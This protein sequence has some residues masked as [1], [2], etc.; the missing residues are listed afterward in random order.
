MS[1]ACTLP[2]L[3]KLFSLSLLLLLISLLF[4]LLLLLIILLML[5]SLVVLSLFFQVMDATAHAKH[6]LLTCLPPKHTETTGI[7]IYIYIYTFITIYIY[8]YIQLL[9]NYMDL[10]AASSCFS[11]SS[12][13]SDSACSRSA[14]L[15]SGRHYLSNSGGIISLTLL[16]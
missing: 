2:F 9:E 7:L 5:L 15:A 6:K 4:L 13:A 10:E 1:H 11:C 14:M 16:V 3:F 8:N 12:A